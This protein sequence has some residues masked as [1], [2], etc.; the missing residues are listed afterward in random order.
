MTPESQTRAKARAAVVSIV[1]NTSLIALKITAGLLTGSVGI[2]SDAA[3]SLMDLIASVIAFASVRKSDEPADATHRYGHEKLEDLAAGAQA[4]LL[5]LGAAF[6]AFEA[7]RRL[8]DGG[9]ITSVG[10]GVTVAGL[11]A[12]TNLVVSTYLARTGRTTRSAALH[13]TAVDLRTDA[14]VSLGVLVSLALVG[15][16][17]ANWIDPI[18]GLVIAAAIST[19][20]VRILLDSARRLV[21][22]A[23]P[24]DELAQLHAVVG[25]FLGDEVVGFHDLRARHVG[26]NHQ[27]DL[28]LQFVAGTSLERA[29]AVSH[30]LQDAIVEALPATTVLVHLEPEGSVRPDRFGDPDTI[31]QQPAATG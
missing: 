27:V 7:I 31:P 26:S 9:T 10:I 2:L 28:H 17:G 6:I 11:A 5:L 16:T 1:S 3:H 24:A 30:R 20:G 23:L 19:S 29:H 15:L 13:A 14:I 25:S 18:A 12:V 21:D 4:L 8:V 22:E